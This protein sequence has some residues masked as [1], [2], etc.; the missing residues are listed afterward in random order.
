MTERLT[1]PGISGEAFEHPWDR[2]ALDALRK[3]P[4]IDALFRKLGALRFERQV[5]LFYTADSLRLSPRQRPDIHELLVDACQV[6]DVPVPEFYLMQAPY[7]N[8]FT[9]GM[10]RSAIVLTSGLVDLMDADE[11]RAVIGHEVGHVKSGHMLYRT[12]AVFLSMLGLAAARNVPYVNVLSQALLHGFY[13]WMRKSEF[14]ADR[15]GLLVAQDRDI[16]VRMLLKLASGVRDVGSGLSVDAFLQQADDYEDMDASLLNVLYK[17][18]LTRFQSHPFPALRAREIVRWVGSDD[19][20]AVLR[21][22][23]P[24]EEGGPGDRR[25]PR[26]AARIASPI[27]RFC[28]ECGAPVGECHGSGAD[29]V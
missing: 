27:Y 5:R 10:D 24:R 14:T 29:S 22:E 7:P 23:Y 16:C 3:T 2:A 9:M 15:A 1:F 8:A 20:R 17:I 19:Y 4:G 11:L 6:L 12:I 21:G 25:C 26:C 13:D 18:E 28:P